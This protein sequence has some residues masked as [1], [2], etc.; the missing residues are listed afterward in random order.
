MTEPALPPPP[1]HKPL[2]DENIVCFSTADWDTPLPTNKHQLMARLARRNR[3]LYIETLGTRA[4]QLSSGVDLARI[5]RRI[6][7][8]ISGPEQRGKR[9]WTLSPLVRPAWRTAPERA[10]NRL[11]F[12]TQAAGALADFPDSIAW[13]YSP[14][15]VYLLDL[16]KPRGVVYHMVD[17]LSAVPGADAE[18]LLEAE[19]RLLARADLVFCTERSLHDR[20]RRTNPSARFLPNVADYRHFSNPKPAAGPTLEVLRSLPRPRLVF[21]GNLAPHKVDL[22]LLARLAA[23]RPDWSIVVI[24]PRW[25]GAAPHPALAALEAAPNAR[26]LGHVPYKDLPAHLHEADVLL[27]PYVKTKATQAVFPLKF[28]ECLAT[29]RPV[30]ASPLPSLLPYKGAVTFGTTPERWIKAIEAALADPEGWRAR[31]VALARRHTWA[32]RL[33]EMEQEIVATLGRRV[34]PPP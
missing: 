21:S 32:V 3:V 8:G 29:G 26:L 14:Y 10:V 16:L 18:A 34:P 30:V 27:I 9:L 25:E 5:G 23:E 31:R 11:A 4:P 1:A 28:F 33:R 12:R 6:G 22:G 13:V 15:A 19:Q 2:W 20:A 17:D 7:R 24:G